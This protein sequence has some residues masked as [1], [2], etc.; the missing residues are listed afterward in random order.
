MVGD[1]RGEDLA[2]MSLELGKELVFLADV[3]GSIG[4][5]FSIVYGAVFL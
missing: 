5:I 1:G 4:L 3:L 2:L